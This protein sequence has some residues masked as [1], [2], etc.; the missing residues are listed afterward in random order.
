MPTCRGATFSVYLRQLSTHPPT[1]F[2]ET[3]RTLILLLCLGFSA[4]ASHKRAGE[5]V[6]RHLGGSNFEITVI[7]YQNTGST[8]DN[9]YIMLYFGNG[10]SA[11]VYRS[12]G[13][14][15]SLS[16][17]LK[18]NLYTTNYSYS[19]GNYIL[20]TTLLNRNFDIVNMTNSGGEPLILRANL[21]VGLMPNSSPVMMVDPIDTAC[22]GDCYYHNPVAVDPD[23]DSLSYHLIPCSGSQ[24]GY[25]AGYYLPAPP[26][27]IS[28]DVL[29]GELSWCSPYAVLGYN[30]PQMWNFAIQ[31]KE[32]RRNPFG[33]MTNI[34]WTIRDMQ[35]NVVQNCNNDPPQLNLVNDLCVLE[36]TS[37]SV[38]VNATD[39]QGG[40]VTL[41]AAGSPFQENPSAVFSSVPAINPVGLFTWT[42][43]CEQVRL[44]PYLVVFKAKDQGPT[45]NLTDL[46]SF[47]IRVIAR[48][49]ADLKAFATCGSVDLNWRSS[50]CDPVS[51][52]VTGY[53][54]YWDDHCNSWMPDSCETDVPLYTG[55]KLA[56]SVNG[57]STTN[58]SITGLTPGNFYSFRVVTRFK[59]GSRSVAS[60]PLCLRI[61]QLTPVLT[62]VDVTAT[63]AS[64][65]SMD[66]RWVNPAHDPNGFDTLNWTGPYT[67]NLR[68]GVGYQNV[69][70]IVFTYTVNYFSQ[71][72]TSLFTDQNLNTVGTPY[73]YQTE[74]LANGNPACASKASSIWLSITPSDNQLTL[75][76]TEVVPWDN[77]QYRI[78]KQA[79]PSLWIL[80]D[81]TSASSYTDTGLVN[82][83]SYCYYVE[84]KGFYSDPL[85]PSPLMNRSEIRCGIPV[86]KTAP[87]APV[88][89]VESLCENQENQ[90]NWTNPN[91][92]C[93]DD[94]VGY[95][96]WY[97]ADENADPY[98]IATISPASVTTYTHDSLTSV[99]GCYFITA[100]DSFNNES[101]PSAR[102]CLDNCPVYELPNVFTPNGDGNNDLF[103][104]FPYRYV[105]SVELVIY[106]RWGA[107][108]FET[109]DPNIGWN[110]INLQSGKQC[111]DGVYYY[112]CRVFERRLKGLENRNIAGYL[113]ILDSK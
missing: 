10:D 63:S 56:G 96:L 95:H 39:P 41:S 65:G 4:V 45:V 8:V 83:A 78:W 107:V 51:N 6:Y 103:V 43:G 86:D 87:C 112:T 11:Q 33:N 27:G 20:H 12:N 26:N 77:V 62:H 90:F 34:G 35:V 66:V 38:S 30:F 75:S 89:N 14:G 17:L 54:I 69:T 15:D 80:L 24:N 104:P 25:A 40:I 84:G 60:L 67:F 79:A 37:I 99:A 91:L 18:K 36:G 61:P 42:P 57:V 32:W 71:L 53:L 74:L 48:G 28:L 102:I 52:P 21:Q 44:Q 5:I 16:P 29:T 70:Q 109:K 106:D 100:I 72:T 58:F 93:S 94:V 19:P 31:I 64:N 111:S 76:W 101:A 82:G 105:E 9:P 88:L 2:I 46:E 13:N 98:I 85:M 59:D 55:Y 73:V 108:I 68:R 1:R 81:S 113:H 47:Y 22:L 49:P 50:S 110:G 7:T 97:M 3:M 92:S 23:G